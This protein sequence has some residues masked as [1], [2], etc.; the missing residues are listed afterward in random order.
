MRRGFLAFVTTTAFLMASC[1]GSSGPAILTGHF[2]DSPV[3][4][5]RYSTAT[6]SG[7]TDA[8]GM[9]H[10][11]AGE[12]ITF[13]L[14]DTV[15]GLPVPAK[16]EMTP[17]D[18]VPGA[19]LYTEP[20]QVK[21]LVNEKRFNYEIR[22][23]HQVVNILVFLQSLDD[24]ADTGNG[25]NI[26]DGVSELFTG[27]PVDFNHSMLSFS[28]ENPVLSVRAHQAA[29]AGLISTAA[30]VKITYALDNFYNA[31]GISLKFAVPATITYNDIA[32]DSQDYFTTTIY[33]A[34]GNIITSKNDTDLDG[35]PDIIITST[36]DDYGNQL[37]SSS[38]DDGDSDPDYIIVSTYDANGNLLTKSYDFDGD[39]TIDAIHTFKFDDNG[40]VQT[41]TVNDPADEVLDNISTYTHNANGN[42]LT[43]SYDGDANNTPDRITTYTYDSNGNKL[44]ISYDYDANGVPNS[45]FIYTYDSNGNRLTES[46]D[47]DANNFPDTLNVYT[48]NANGY[49]LTR[50]MDN[51]ADGYIDSSTTYKYDAKGNLLTILEDSDGDGDSNSFETYT[52]TYDANSNRLTESND[53]DRNGSTDSVAV[54]EYDMNEN[55]LKKT[56]TFYDL[57]VART[58]IKTYTYDVNGN[59]LTESAYTDIDSNPDSI[60]TLDLQKGNWNML[61]NSLSVAFR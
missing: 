55:L 5:L 14:G 45:I 10:Y 59:M 27:M 6:Q 33:D 13:S 47:N 32:D 12:A 56:Q 29:N 46:W 11:L 28:D 58:V 51:M 48:Y 31:Q 20:A 42:L 15:I 9:F 39:D 41:Y 49:I 61:I 52:A 25:I 26:P 22:T 19:I 17:I 35:M 57:G 30:L 44:T 24:D 23:F 21:K 50:D 7:V 37:T 16:N 18:L 36:Y 54:N 60:K 40:N 4:G 34:R 8:E 38:D 1:G 3:A 2:T 53:Y 43:D